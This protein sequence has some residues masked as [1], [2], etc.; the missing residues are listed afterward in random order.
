M[1]QQKYIHL[2][3]VLTVGNK[4]EKA[5]HLKCV[6]DGRAS[7]LETFWKQREIE[8]V[9]DANPDIRLFLDSGAHSLLNAKAGLINSSGIVKS[10]KTI[11]NHG[12]AEFT[13]DEFA[14]LPIAERAALAAGG[15]GMIQKFVD[16]SFTED[17]DVKQYLDAYIEF[18]HKY[19]KQ[20]LGYVNLDIIYNAE[21]SWINQEYMES[22]GLRPVPVFHHE[23]DFKWLKKYVDE[24]EYIG[25]GGVAT[26]LGME[27][28]LGFADA[29]FEIIGYEHPKVQVHGFAVTSFDMMFRY[30]WYSVD[31]TSW[32]KHAAYGNVIVPRWSEV[33]NDFDL[34]RSPMTATVSNVALI[35]PTKGT[36]IHYTKKYSPHERERIEL[37]FEQCGTCFVGP[38]SD[39]T[40]PGVGVGD[41]LLDRQRVNIH[42]YDQLLKK[43]IVVDA[44]RAHGNKV[45]F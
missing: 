28:F 42:Y 30:P 21:R 8:K 39:G 32:L 18:I 6:Q 23:E 43:G 11:E 13:A 15:R 24:Y 20:L 7:S 2:A 35:K 1:A 5:D 17:E 12:E 45:F 16:W 27:A 22:H 29:C 36:T 3:N 14:N 10:V 19:E 33:L 9:L 4:V 34:G 31:S 25:I 26:G 38:N 41:I 40:L 37:W 44:A